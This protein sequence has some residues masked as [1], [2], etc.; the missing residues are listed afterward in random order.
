MKRRT[1]IKKTKVLAEDPNSLSSN[2]MSEEPDTPS[3]KEITEAR[4][5]S[6]IS[7]DLPTVV[8]IKESEKET[9]R[10]MT[11]IMTISRNGAGFTLP[12]PCA[13]GRI[14]R[15]VLPM[16]LELRAYD[17]SEELYP[18]M[19]VVQN[20][21]KISDDSE[22]LYHV[23]VAL[24]GKKVPES[25]LENPLQTYRI[26]GMSEDGLW[27]VL[28]AQTPHKERKHTRYW[29]QLDVRLTLLDKDTRQVTKETTTTR[30]V[31][32]KGASVAS[33]LDAKV[34]DTVKFACKGLNFYA[35]AVVR[36]RRKLV[37]QK[38]TLHL[39]FIE[40]TFPVEKLTHFQPPEP[41]KTAEPMLD[42]Q[43]SARSLLANYLE[44][45]EVERF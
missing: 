10:G 19:A 28:E 21:N 12:R 11:D 36:N 44:E 25:Y 37:D 24:I 1:K 4:I 17:V 15:L 9:W 33:S 5:V 16:P 43:E 6:R 29:A 45:F 38:P 32:F 13:I 22:G 14:V 2:E 3:S 18:I 8:Q 26:N 35:M 27:T 39:E 42:E 34:G 30:N 31:G 41:T 40:C 23:G 20:C 7:I